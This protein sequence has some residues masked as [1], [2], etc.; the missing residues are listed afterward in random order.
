MCTYVCI[1]FVISFF[2][3]LCALGTHWANYSVA[4]PM[5]NCGNAGIPQSGKN[6]AHNLLY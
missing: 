6:S 1:H 3:L 4:F 5:E 2:S